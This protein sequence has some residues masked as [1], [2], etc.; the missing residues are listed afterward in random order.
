MLSPSFDQMGTPYL[1]ATDRE[2]KG[3]DDFFLWFW[4]LFSETIHWLFV[5]QQARQDGPYS[6]HGYLIGLFSYL[7]TT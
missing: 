6:L 2:R 7:K 5:K 4:E 1:S 3:D